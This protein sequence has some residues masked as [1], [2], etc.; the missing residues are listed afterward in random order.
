MQPE[1]YE[2]LATDPFN[3]RIA[4]LKAENLA[5]QDIVLQPLDSRKVIILHKNKWV[6]GYLY[7]DS[8]ATSTVDSPATSTKDKEIFPEERA[9][10]ETLIRKLYGQVKQYLSTKQIQEVP[11]ELHE[12]ITKV[13]MNSPDQQVMVRY[14]PINNIQHFKN[15]SMENEPYGESYYSDLLLIIMII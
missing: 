10:S 4:Q 3:V 1:A 12:I 11:E 8:P 13:L 5:I 14:I 7:V 15:P 6:M 9:P 2:K